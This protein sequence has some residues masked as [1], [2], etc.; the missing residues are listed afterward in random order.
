[1]AVDLSDPISMR[2]PRDVLASVEQ[3]AK[4]TDR[5][6]SWVIVRAL[7]RYMAT[8]GADILAVIDG[9]KQIATGESHDMG[10]VLDEIERLTR[11]PATDVA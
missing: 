10:D 7:R 5:S 9:R 3:V 1:M 11:A 4:A 6:R 8:E 2:L